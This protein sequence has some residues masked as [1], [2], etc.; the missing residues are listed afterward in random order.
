MNR[1]LLIFT[2]ALLAASCAPSPAAIARAVAQTQ[3]AWTP[4]PTQTPYSTYTPASSQTPAPTVVVT[5]EVTRIVDQPV[6]A[7]PTTHLEQSSTPEPPTATLE[8][9]VTPR[10]FTPL[11]P[12]PI[13]GRHSAQPGD[14]I[15]C[16][17]RAYGVLP[18]AIAQA[19][20]LSFTSL[21]RSGQVLDI[22]AV[23]WINISAGPVCATQFVSP[24]SGLVVATTTPQAT[25][26]PASARLNVSVTANCVGNCGSDQGTYDLQV[27]VFVEGGIGPYTFNPGQSYHVTFPHCTNASGTVSVTSADV[28]TG[29]ASWSYH[30]AGCP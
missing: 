26:T 27:D 23:Q 4:V 21:I 28:Q 11:P 10:P 19:N 6:L 15:F 24:F 7:S 9:T 14:T 16:I 2:G 20:G 1:W 8:P 12:S 5:V 22:P 3:S 29:V 18:G 17:A 30:D 25:A 13:I